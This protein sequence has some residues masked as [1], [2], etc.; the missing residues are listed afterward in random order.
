MTTTSQNGRSCSRSSRQGSAYASRHA[1]NKKLLKYT[2]PAVI[3]AENEPPTR[4]PL[5]HIMVNV[6][7][8][9]DISSLHVFKAVKNILETTL[10]RNQA[11]RPKGSTRE[12]RNEKESRNEEC[13]VLKAKAYDNEMEFKRQCN[14]G[15]RLDLGKVGRM[16]WRGFMK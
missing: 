13:K 10:P 6:E 5:A 16:Y 11:G 8:V 7:Q 15:N 12:G 3:S 4:A 9:S 14:L 2:K 1:I